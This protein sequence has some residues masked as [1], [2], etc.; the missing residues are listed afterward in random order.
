MNNAIDINDANAI[1]RGVFWFGILCTMGGVALLI[2]GVLLGF[3]SVGLTQLGL[4]TPPGVL[5]LG[6]TLCAIALGC[7]IAALILAKVPPLFGIRSI[8]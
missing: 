4:K 3:L 6:V 7:I 8:K 5:S 2:I 1:E